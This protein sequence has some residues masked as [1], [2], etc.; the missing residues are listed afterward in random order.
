MLPS[1]IYARLANLIS[2][3]P[4][5]LSREGEGWGRGSTTVCVRR[6]SE[7]PIRVDYPSRLSESTIRVDYPSRL[8]RCS[9]AH[10]LVL[11]PVWPGALGLVPGAG[12]ARGVSRGTGAAATA[13]TPAGR[14]TRRRGGAARGRGARGRPS[15]P[16]GPTAAGPR[17]PP[18][19]PAAPLRAPAVETGQTRL[20]TGQSMRYKEPGTRRSTDDREGALPHPL[21][22]T[23]ARHPT[24]PPVRAR[25]L[26]C[27]PRPAGVVCA[28]PASRQRGPRAG[29]RRRSAPRA[30]DAGR[31]DDRGLDEDR[32]RNEAAPRKEPARRRGRGASRA[33]R[34]RGGGGG[35]WCGTWRAPVGHLRTGRAG[36]EGWGGGEGAR[37]GV[38]GAVVVVLAPAG[39]GREERPVRRRRCAAHADAHADAGS[40]GVMPDG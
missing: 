40:G 38:E 5:P 39:V 7:S 15:A 8:S 2:P 28:S 16:P 3:P 35:R 10:A 20:E 1:P 17:G 23:T 31:R 9:D 4:P 21:S 25:A 6:L 13:G 29:R 12:D 18:G 27:V 37:G 22:N 11:V 36:R 24:R 14:A 34:R 19:S 30:G 26:A 33:A 32:P